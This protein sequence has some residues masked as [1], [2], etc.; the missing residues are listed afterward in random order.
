[1]AGG[2]L[3]AVPM[4]GWAA[5]GGPAA[6]LAEPCAIFPADG[7]TGAPLSYTDDGT[8]TGDKTGLM[9]ERSRPARSAIRLTAPS[10]GRRGPVSIFD[11]SVSW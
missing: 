4:L 9:W 1:M 7:S 8:F 5:K 3:L 10:N 6:C 11:K 2:L